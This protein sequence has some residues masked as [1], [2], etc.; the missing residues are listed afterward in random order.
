LRFG[1]SAGDS[2][3]I[4]KK[5]NSK[6]AIQNLQFKTWQTLTKRHEHWRRSAGGRISMFNLLLGFQV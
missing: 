2:L 3:G 1:F 5:I 6:P 4:S